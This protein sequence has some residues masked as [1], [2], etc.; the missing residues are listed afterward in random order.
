MLSGAA[1]IQKHAS[2]HCETVMPE[3]LEELKK[4]RKILPVV[5]VGQI[6]MATL[7]VSLKNNENYRI[8]KVIIFHIL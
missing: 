4:L 5:S 1:K 7:L 6:L 8:N 3:I 2:S